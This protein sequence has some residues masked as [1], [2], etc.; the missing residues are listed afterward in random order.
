LHINEIEAE[1]IRAIF[2]M[3]GE[4]KGLREIARELNEGG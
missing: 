3:K 4:N 2:R 1:T